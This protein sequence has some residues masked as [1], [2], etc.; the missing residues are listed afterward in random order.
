MKEKNIDEIA[1]NL[2]IRNEVAKMANSLYVLSDHLSDE[3]ILFL[4]KK[5][6]EQNNILKVQTS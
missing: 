5:V 6:M 1:E 3:E 2:T 4:V